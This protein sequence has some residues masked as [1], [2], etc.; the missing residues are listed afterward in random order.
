[1]LIYKQNFYRNQ[2]I[3]VIIM[4]IIKFGNTSRIETFDGRKE[5]TRTGCVHS[6]IPASLGYGVN[7]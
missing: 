2:G 3:K 1:M 6:L 4:C 7:K 5:S